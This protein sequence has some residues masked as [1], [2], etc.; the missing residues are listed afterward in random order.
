MVANSQMHDDCSDR[1]KFLHRVAK[2]MLSLADR[3]PSIALEL[4]QMA[5]DLESTA[6]K[7]LDCTA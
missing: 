1:P 2:E 7:I 6:E 5:A 4:G 3:D